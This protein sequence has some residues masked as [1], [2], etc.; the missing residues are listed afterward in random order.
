ME[1]LTHITPSRGPRIKVQKIPVYLHFLGITEIAGRRVWYEE[2][3]AAHVLR[4]AVS[5]QEA[6]R[7]WRS[8]EDE[9]TI[10]EVWSRSPVARTP[11]E[12][13]D[14]RLTGLFELMLEDIPL[15]EVDEMAIL[16]EKTEL[17]FDDE[18]EDEADEDEDED[19]EMEDEE[20]SFF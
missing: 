5:Y 13:Q 11:L 1:K 6:V 16:P 15:A 10:F 19:G 3:M 7:L 12:G 17:F 9:D 2:T 14:S 20:D 18:D 8:G 4:P